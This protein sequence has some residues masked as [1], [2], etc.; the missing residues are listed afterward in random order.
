MSPKRTLAPSRKQRRLFAVL[1][2][3]ALATVVIASR[4][5]AAGQ[6]GAASQP[7]SASPPG[8]LFITPPTITLSASQPETAIF[9]T[10]DG[11]NP[12][13]SPTRARF[14][15]PFALSGSALV[16]FL[17]EQPDGSRSATHS[18]TFIVTT[19]TPL[20]GEPPSSGPELVSLKGHPVPEPSNLGQFVTDRAAAIAL[21]KALFWDMQVGSDGVT[22]CASCHFA[23]GADNRSKN[24]VNP[25]LIAGDNAFTLPPNRQLQLS[26]FPLHRLADPANRHSAVLA[27]TNDVIS[28][29]GVFAGIFRGIVFGQPADDVDSSA[30]DPVFNVKGEQVRRVEPRNTP[31]TLNAVFN[32]RN[33]W[34]GRAQNDF[35]GVSPFGSRDPGAFVVRSDGKKQLEKVRISIPDASLAS[36]AVGPP[37]SSFEMSGDG[38]ILPDIGVKLAK[39]IRA[40]GKKLGSL[41]PLAL[42]A[43]SHSDGVLGSYAAA[44]GKGL[45]VS[46]SALI[47]KAFKQ[48]WW[49]TQN[50]G[51]RVAKD[52]SLTFLKSAPKK[53]GEDEFELMEYNFSLFFGLAIQLYEATLVTSDTPY[54]RF[55][56]GQKDALTSAQKRGLVTFQTKGHCINCHG[57][58]ELTN[59]STRNVRN[60]RL[61]LMEMGDQQMAIYDNGF[62]NIGVRPTAEDLGVGGVDP[63]GNPLSE[64]RLAKLGKFVD[65][66]QPVSSSSRVAVDGAF[67]T[68]G[69]RNV[70]LTAPYFHNGGQATLR[71]VVEFYN[72]GGDF[73]ENNL[74]NLDPDIETLGLDAREQDDLVDFL[75]AL[76]DDRVVN[77]KAPFDH[78][79]LFL[80]N[81]H[82][83]DEHGIAGA[84]GG[85]APDVSP[86]LE[87]PAVGASGGPP[88][89]LFLGQQQ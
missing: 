4:N 43:V 31:T 35:N 8:G 9:F 58:A 39:F 76:T 12:A 30:G 41:R 79:Q 6:T 71:Q 86:L 49:K 29:Q 56:S 44:N 81:G 48:E 75:R 27:D 13:N 59:A 61:E 11:S 67:K 15:A 14:T 47:E 28:S 37:L 70:A 54:D 5:P 45:N 57:G 78:P 87:L 36:Q 26:D 10:L 52:G 46:Y 83:G 34:D 69:L 51:I 20:P 66:K 72:R 33:F 38:R 62:Y 53:L 22:A 16:H 2:I 24:Q 7:V 85:K 23:G 74:A 80:T 89:P 64:S 40:R 65:P 60:E 84:S 18:E 1:G 68:P 32:F 3:A 73:H 42:Q 50:V 21:G 25:G 77:R 19:P 63:W 17:A 55:L 82:P 88:L